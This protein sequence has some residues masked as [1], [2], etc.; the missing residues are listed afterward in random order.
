[1]YKDHLTVVVVNNIHGR[2]FKNNRWSIRQG[3]R[4]SSILFCYGLDPHLDWLEF[5]LRGIPIYKNLK[6]E[7]PATEVYKLI[8]YVDDVKP[9]ITCMNDFLIVD[10]GSA[11]FEAASGCKLHRDPTSGKVKFLPLCRWKGTLTKEDL[12]VNYIAMSEHLDM[13]GVKL[14]ASYQKTRKLNGHELQSKV[15]TVIG[16]WR[17]GKYMPLINRPHSINTYC[18]SKVWF[19][20]AT[21]NP[22]VCDVSK[23]TSSVKSWLFADQL[24]KPEEVVLH[25]PRKLGGLGLM[26]VQYKALSLLI[27]TFLETAIIPKFKHN[28]YHTALYLWHI[29]G[30]KDITCPVQPPYYDDSFFNTIKQVKQEGLLN[31]KTMSSA[32]WYRVLVESNITH[33]IKNS[34]NEYIPCR[35]EAKLPGIDW[36]RSWSLA[37]TPGLPS[38]SLTFVWKM[39]HNLLPTPS[40]LFRLKMPHTSSNLCN[41]CNQD[42]VGDL[43]HCLLQC[44]YNDGADQFLMSKLSKVLPNILP[45]DVVHLDFDA[46]D[47]QLPLVYLAASVLSQIWACRVEKKPCKLFAIRASLEASINIL[48]KSRHRSAAESLLVIL[49]TA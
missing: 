25:R 19:R 13:V 42:Q 48:R 20:C 17:S 22:R 35:A 3:D 11:L 43:S 40:R 12:P 23:I 15:Q 16:A 34:R 38:S 31:L 24:E 46:G 28:Q 29:E 44:S 37:A 18:L 2:C 49:D 47:L 26:N 1:M 6:A 33:E 39:K 21:V 36:E 41:L 4:P 5:R 7:N 45:N 27:R 32:Q 30:D 10:N 8:A 14:T 9:S